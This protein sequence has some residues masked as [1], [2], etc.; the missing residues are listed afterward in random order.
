[1]P[2]K[3]FRGHGRN[4]APVCVIGSTQVRKSV[5][6]QCRRAIA[7]EIIRARVPLPITQRIPCEMRA[8]MEIKRDECDERGP[9][10]IALMTIETVRTP[11]PVTVDK[12]P[13]PKVIWR[14][15]KWFI[16]DPG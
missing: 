1:M 11:G 8:A 9:P 3:I 6:M 10:P 13:A 12:N 7:L 14:P 5:E 4:R 2:A 16:A 15:A